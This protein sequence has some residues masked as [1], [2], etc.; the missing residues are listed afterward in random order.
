MRALVLTLAFVLCAAAPPETRPAF[1]LAGTGAAQVLLVLGDGWDAPTGTLWRFE[2]DGDRYRRVGDGVPVVVG[3]NGLAWGLGLSPP[4]PGNEPQKREG[5]GRAPAGVFRLGTAVG[6]AEKAPEGVTLP[7]RPATPGLRCVDDPASPHYNT[8][9]D[10]DAVTPDWKSAEVMRRDDGLYEM[11]VTVAHNADPPRPGA[12]SCIFVH[13][14][15]AAGRGTAGCTAMD[16]ADLLGVLRWLSPEAK[17]VLVQLP[18]AVFP[19]YAAAWGLPSPQA[20]P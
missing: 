11:L 20:A 12:G 3:R 10:Q 1:T 13:V 18:K 9:V 16:R 6:Y 2:R 19:A 8:Y 14:W 17:P 4:G 15:R 5:D 7:W